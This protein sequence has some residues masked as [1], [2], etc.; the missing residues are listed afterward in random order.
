MQERT[1]EGTRETENTIHYA[2]KC[3][4]TH[5]KNKATFKRKMAWADFG[6]VCGAELGLDMIECVLVGGGEERSGPVPH[7]T[8]ARPC[9]V[10]RVTWVRPGQNKDGLSGRCGAN[11]T[12]SANLTLETM[13]RLNSLCS[14]CRWAPV[15][16]SRILFKRD[17]LLIAHFL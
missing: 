3:M 14:R 13:Q 8:S 5:A 11:A 1:R 2:L 12:L 17:F 10:D 15:L 9:R 6:C 4:Q 7:K 16:C